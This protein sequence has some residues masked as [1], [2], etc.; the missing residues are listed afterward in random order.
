V[1][2]DLQLASTQSATRFEVCLEVEFQPG[3]PKMSIVVTIFQQHY[4]DGLAR[5][6]L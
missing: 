1:R 2:Y 6:W 3:D 4:R 5:L